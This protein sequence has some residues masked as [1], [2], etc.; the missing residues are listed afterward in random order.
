MSGLLTHRSSK[1]A[2]CPPSSLSPHKPGDVTSTKTCQSKRRNCPDELHSSSVAECGARVSV[3]D[4]FGLRIKRPVD[5]AA[6]QPDTSETTRLGYEAKIRSKRT[7]LSSDTARVSPIVVSPRRP[8]RLSVR[9]A[10]TTVLSV[11][12]RYD[13]PR[14]PR[15]PRPPA[16][17]YPDLT[18]LVTSWRPPRVA[19]PRRQTRARR[20]PYPVHAESR[21]STGRTRRRS[22][23]ARQRC[24]RG[25]S[26]T[27]RRRIRRS[28]DRLNG[29]PVVTSRHR[30]TRFHPFCSPLSAT[31]SPEP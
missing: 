6:F 7:R 27:C 5:S 22:P 24:H 19:H 29:A 10:R 16:R 15:S 2:E 3:D 25:R 28:S 20:Y 8:P 13:A 26:P 9:S 18:S 17:R 4:T 31:S 1:R 23:P 30:F 21:R 11:F 14:R 12:S